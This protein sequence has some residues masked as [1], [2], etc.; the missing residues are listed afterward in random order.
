[1]A[2]LVAGRKEVVVPNML[3]VFFGLEGGLAILVS[4]VLNCAVC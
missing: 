3:A 4:L 2:Y 1:V